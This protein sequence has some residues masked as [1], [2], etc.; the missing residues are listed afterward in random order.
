M[1]ASS[2]ERKMRRVYVLG[3]GF[4][5]EI[6]SAMPVLADL[7]PHVEAMI[8]SAP[9]PPRLGPAD[10]GNDVERWLSHLASPPPWISPA[11]SLRDRATF[12]DA[13]KML[14]AVIESAQIK[15]LNLQPPDWLTTLVKYWRRFEESVITFNYDVLVERA[16]MHTCT[17]EGDDTRFAADL[18]AIPLAPLATRG[19]SIIGGGRTQSFKLLKLHG[20]T[21]WYYS[22]PGAGLSDTIYDSGLYEQHWPASG[23]DLVDPDVDELTADK[24]PLLIPP[25]AVKT[26]FYENSALRVQW[27]AAARAISEADEVV[28]MGFS[29]PTT[30]LLVREL[31]ATNLPKNAEV[32]VVNK[33]V[34]L[35]D[36]LASVLDI[37]RPRVVDD[38]C[39]TNALP[40]W[41]GFCAS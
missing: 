40:H 19:S 25:V 18:Y 5:K 1:H 9:A 15:A 17:T 35:P 21:N 24:T 39:C 26:T 20:S 10:F 6:N 22:G 11:E 8:A 34:D 27:Q 36:H 16:Y 33:D 23:N 7:T 32:V 37:E 3:S 14:A 30:D 41:V 4:S 28:L 13:S 29:V 2:K 12:L 38:F 31:I